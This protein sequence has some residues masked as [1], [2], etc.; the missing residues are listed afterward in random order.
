MRKKT[1][2]IWTI[3]KTE[4][5]Q[6]IEKSNSLS[7]VLR[8]L[9]LDPSASGSRFRSLKQRFKEDCIDYSHIKLGVFSNKGRKFSREAFPL[10]KVMIKNSTYSRSTLK[11][12]QS[13]SY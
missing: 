10:E 1:S 8:N 9:N 13:R 3:S 11:R 4:L 5:E 6:I 2:P 7:D 12:R